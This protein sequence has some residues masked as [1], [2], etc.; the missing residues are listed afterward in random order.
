MI[1]VPWD[2]IKIDRSRLAC[3]L[4]D[5]NLNVVVSAYHPEAKGGHKLIIGGADSK[6]RVAGGKGKVSGAR[7]RPAGI[8]RPAPLVDRSPRRRNLRVVDEGRSTK[9]K[10]IYSKRIRNL[11][12]GEDLVVEGRYLANIKHLPYDVRTRTQIVLARSP[13]SIQHNSRRARRAA[14]T[15]ARITEENNFNCTHKPSGHS[16]PCPII[17]VGIVRIARAST[18]PLFVNLIAGHGALIDSDQSFRPG[19]VHVPKSGGW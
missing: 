18:K 1:T 10:V 8:D 5:C 17:K 14:A 12:A 15:D 16:S 19:S 2:G 9:L 6:G 13:D 3:P 7:F 4:N 11:R